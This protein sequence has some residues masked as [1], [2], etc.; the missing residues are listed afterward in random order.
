MDKKDKKRGRVFLQSLGCKTNQYENDA[1]AAAFAA[2]GFSLVGAESTADVAVLNTCS[3]T[4]EAGR[5]SRQ[6]LRRLKKR[7]PDALIVASG[8]HAQLSDLSELSDITVGT[9]GRDQ[10]VE[11]VIQKLADREA[12]GVIQAEDPYAYETIA[13]VSLPSETRAYIK[14]EDGCDNRCS[15]CAIRL[16]RGRVRSRSP[17]SIET[18]VLAL[19]GRGFTEFIL[20]GTHIGAY[21]KGESFDFIGLLERLDQLAVGR[22]RL[23]SLEPKTISEAFME[24][25]A[26]FRHVCPHIHLSLQ[27][28]SDTVLR[29]MRRRYDS[30]RYKEAVERIFRV[31]PKAGLT[32]DVIVG[33][34]G[35]TDEEH[36]ASVDFL[37]ALPFTDFHVFR[38]SP[39]EGTEAYEME[40][41]VDPDVKRLRSREMEMLAAEKKRQ[42]VI[43]RVG[44]TRQLI[45][46]KISDAVAYGYTEDYLYLAVDLSGETVSS[47]ELI[48]VEVSG[49]D[50]QVATAR[51]RST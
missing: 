48:T 32:T 37:S 13:P 51:L 11:A 27:S 50:D 43:D 7:F 39:R 47:K 4:A 18:E 15:Y 44:E 38:F 36:K 46:E 12:Q 3:V 1:L 31:W 9:S 5:K 33:F 10:I 42:A 6:M 35:E 45:V 20:T 17:E 28:G 25:A 49:I 29:R 41:Q 8:C 22:I 19:A 26:S 34:P 2:A 16:A 30:R 14:I 23:G 24:K 21:G 40:G